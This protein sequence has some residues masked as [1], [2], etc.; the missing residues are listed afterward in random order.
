MENKHV[1]ILIYLTFFMCCT[2]LICNLSPNVRSLH[3]HSYKFLIY[4]AIDSEL[5]NA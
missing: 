2:N 4:H 3:R 1:D 5:L